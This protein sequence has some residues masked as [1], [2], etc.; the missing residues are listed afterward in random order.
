MRSCYPSSS[1]CASK[2]E[3]HLLV[4]KLVINTKYSR[5]TFYFI[6][7][8]GIFF[9][10]LNQVQLMPPY[11]LGKIKHT[12]GKSNFSPEMIHVSLN[13]ILPPQ[14]VVC[15]PYYT[16]LR[17]SL[18]ALEHPWGIKSNNNF[19]FQRLFLICRRYGDE[20]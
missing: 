2:T 5:N 16:H 8:F 17:C 14:K 6:I 9:C 11:S 13:T 19:T 20:F 4:A 10:L 15:L 3:G 1:H 7:K 12:V 18:K